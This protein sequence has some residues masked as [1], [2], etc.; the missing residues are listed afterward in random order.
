MDL[1]AMDEI[2]EAA[3]EAALKRQQEDPDDHDI[4]LIGQCLRLS[5]EERL[6]RMAS[7]ANFIIAARTEMRAAKHSP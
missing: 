4:S 6:R 2:V 7:W 5:P 3:I 1:G